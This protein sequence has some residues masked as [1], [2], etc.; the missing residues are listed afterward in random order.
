[1]E[2]EKGMEERSRKEDEVERKKGRQVRR[3]RME[4]QVSDERGGGEER[5]MLRKANGM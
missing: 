1:M 3:D 5:E 4:E 2:E